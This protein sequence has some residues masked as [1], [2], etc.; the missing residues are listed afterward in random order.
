MTKE[1]LARLLFES[2]RPN[3]RYVHADGRNNDDLRN[4]TIVDH[5]DLVDVAE[6]ILARATVEARSLMR[7]VAQHTMR[8]RMTPRPRREELIH[9]SLEG[10][11]LTSTVTR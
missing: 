4:V 8:S 11:P 6:Q 1:K 9:I 2:L 3:E 5:F 7:G 10:Q